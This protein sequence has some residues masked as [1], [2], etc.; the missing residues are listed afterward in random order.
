[1]CIFSNNQSFHLDVK[2]AFC[3]ITI[4]LH[5]IHSLDMLF[6]ICPLYVPCLHVGAV[7]WC[8]SHCWESQSSA[9]WHRENSTA[10]QSVPN[11]LYCVSRLVSVLH[12]YIAVTGVLL[13]SPP[14]SA[15]ARSD[16]DSLMEIYNCWLIY[17]LKQLT[18]TFGLKCPPIEYPSTVVFC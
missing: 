8:A 13:L 4:F 15:K 18:R 14:E 9:G 6:I 7:L 1:M 5:C 3:S 17:L 11:I 2:C 10:F 12:T 16:G